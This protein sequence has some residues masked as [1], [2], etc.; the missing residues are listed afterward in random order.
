MF[1]WIQFVGYENDPVSCSL[2]KY[3]KAG[4]FHSR[5]RTRQRKTWSLVTGTLTVVSWVQMTQMSGDP[6]VSGLWRDQCWSTLFSLQIR[7]QP[8]DHKTIK[9]TADE[10]KIFEGIKH[11]NLVRYFGVELHRVSQ[12]GWHGFVWAISKGTV[13]VLFYIA[14]L[15]IS[16]HSNFA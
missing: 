13:G 10:L 1:S 2:T 4:M 15:L 14:G 7:F 9:E 12:L 16:E 8:N 5:G 11:P 6:L 3:S